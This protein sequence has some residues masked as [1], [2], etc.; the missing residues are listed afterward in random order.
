MPVSRP[1]DRWKGPPGVDF[2]APLAWV[3]WIPV[4]GW[5]DRLTRDSRPPAAPGPTTGRNALILLRS[6]GTA[7]PIAR[8]GACPCLRDRLETRPPPGSHNFRFGLQASPINSDSVRCSPA[9]CAGTRHAVPMRPRASRARGSQQSE[10]SPPRDR[11]GQ[12]ARFATPRWPRW[13]PRA[14]GIPPGRAAVS[15]TEPDL[16][17]LGRTERARASGRGLSRPLRQ[18]V[19]RERRGTPSLAS[20]RRDRGAAR[21]RAASPSATPGS[22]WPGARSGPPP[23]RPVADR[24][25]R[26]RRAR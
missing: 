21:H 7:S 2:S 10:R 22:P 1:L 16:R 11:Q 20:R 26:T 3:R 25:R 9:N 5:L 8:F 12:R 18:L 13:F 23:P 24:E 4:L 14:C 15:Q 19:E 6:L 17:R